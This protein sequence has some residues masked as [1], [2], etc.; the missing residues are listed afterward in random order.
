MFLVDLPAAGR[1]QM[2]EKVDP[3]ITATPTAV[4]LAARWVR[5][6]HGMSYE[7]IGVMDRILG[8]GSDFDVLDKW[9]FLQTTVIELN[10]IRLLLETYG[11]LVIYAPLS[12]RQLNATMLPMPDL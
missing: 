10:R 8:A 9:G 4:Y 11:P 2:S 1:T 6:F 12:H 5:Q 3:K 7:H